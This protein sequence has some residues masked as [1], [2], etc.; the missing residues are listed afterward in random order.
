MKRKRHNPRVKKMS[1]DARR[2]RM[3]ARLERLRDQLRAQG[4]SDWARHL[5]HNYIDKMYSYAWRLSDLAAV[6]KEAKTALRMD[7]ALFK[8]FRGEKS[9]RVIHPSGKYVSRSRS[10]KFNPKRRYRRNHESSAAHS[11]IQ[12]MRRDLPHMYSRTLDPR[13]GLIAA[14]R[15]HGELRQLMKDAHLPND[16]RT[17][18]RTLAAEYRAAI[19]VLRKRDIA[20]LYKNPRRRR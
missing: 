7:Y 9:A 4:Y 3:F 6:E 10:T 1:L 18:A 2:R 15:R 11:D 13:D 12:K 19:D 5:Q 20:R 8:P 14:S 16:V 17:S